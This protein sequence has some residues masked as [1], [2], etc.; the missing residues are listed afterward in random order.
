MKNLV[1]LLVFVS[2]LLVGCFG[3][4]VEGGLVFHTADPSLS[5]FMPV[6][7]ASGGPVAPVE[8]EV[9]PDEEVGET[10]PEPLPEPPCDFMQDGECLP[11]KGNISRDGR[12]LYHTPESPNYDQVK[13]DETA[14][15]KFF[16]TV[17]EAEA[18]G[19]TRAGS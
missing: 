9:V 5:F 19:W 13:I 15:E 18:A 14:G 7:Q 12:K 1:M 16:R 17:E 3:H 2:T 4:P 8:P 6:A 10:L 11:I